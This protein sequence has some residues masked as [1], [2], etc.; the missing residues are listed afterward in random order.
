MRLRRRG[1]VSLSVS[2]GS[3]VWLPSALSPTPTAWYDPSDLST[4][5]KDTAGT[6]PVTADGDAVARIDDKSG[7]GR[8]LTQS[9]AGSR[10][11]Y[12]TSGGISWLQFDGVDD[13]LS[14]ADNDDWE[15]LAG[16]FT[17]AAAASITGS[18]GT[19]VGK[20]LFAA[21]AGRWAIIRSSDVLNSFLLDANNVSKDATSSSDFTSAARVIE[22][23]ISRSANT[24][25]LVVNGIVVST[26]SSVSASSINTSFKPIVGAYWNA[27]QT[28]GQAGFWL[29][30][31]IYGLVFYRGSGSNNLTQW[32]AR[33]A[34][35]ST[36][37]PT[38]SVLLRA[39]TSIDHIGYG[40]AVGDSWLNQQTGTLYK[41]DDSSVGSATWSTVTPGATPCDEI[42]TAAVAAY[43]VTKLR[44]AYAGSAFQVRRA[45]DNATSDIGFDGSGVADW[46]SAI[47]FAGGSQLYLSKWYDQSGNGK[48]AS[49]TSGNQTPLY[50]NTIGSRTGLDFIDGKSI[51][52]TGISL[53][54]Q[55]LTAIA[56]VKPRGSYKAGV[57]NLGSG[58]VTLGH[59]YDGGQQLWQGANDLNPLKWNVDQGIRVAK[60][61][62]TDV[63]SGIDDRTG[64]LSVPGTAL[65]MTTCDLGG[66]NGVY[67]ALI[68]YNTALSAAD[69]TSVRRS[70][71]ASYG[72]STQIR[73]R[74]VLVGDSITHGLNTTDNQGYAH[75]ML[76]SLTRAFSLVNL[77][78]PNQNQVDQTASTYTPYIVA[79]N[80]SVAFVFSGT[81]DLAGGTTASALQTITNNLCTSLK[82]G[83]FTKVVVATV[84][85]RATGFSGGVDA[86]S[87]DTAR[88]TYNTWI[89]ANY[90]TFADALCDFAA[91]A[92]MGPKTAANDVTYY[93]D[94]IHPTSAG[95]AILARIAAAAINAVS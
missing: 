46:A 64:L 68:L 24:N 2:G 4:L 60:L 34:N 49:A 13:Y 59:F 27:T 47:S 73:D 74:L 53:S 58:A 55:N 61:T 63:T 77:G 14:C 56:I 18:T 70:L 9:T 75:K 36:T 89:R 10:P 95:H 51:S 5:W 69:I 6:T 30:G 83:G 57:I 3:S 39:P 81:N 1:S 78:I 16:D 45:S 43:G 20:T 11:L 31:R 54:R 42:G 66:L 7:N 12:K 32:L 23:R 92:T 40:Y 62:S 37:L 21:G 15:A 41:L 22:Q 52:I 76:P 48:D 93:S 17:V 28:G 35:V 71:I 87:F 84:L 19:V 44:A 26:T 65:T 50:R 33:K 38:T 80:R 79:N 8:H 91:D 67:G 72:I 90:G 25:S 94:Q 88:N 29:N 85:P 82:A 86:D